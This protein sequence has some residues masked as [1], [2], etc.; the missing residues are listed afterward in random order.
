MK[1]LVLVIAATAFAYGATGADYDFFDGA[2]YPGAAGRKP[3]V[4]LYRVEQEG[5][6]HDEGHRRRVVHWWPRKGVDIIEIKKGM[7]LR[8]WTFR[9]RQFD[10]KS[11]TVHPI[12]GVDE[13][14]RRLPVTQPRKIK[15]HLVGFRGIGNRAAAWSF[16]TNYCPAVV[17]RLESGIKRCFIRRTFIEED[18]A[19]ILDTYE[20][21]MDRVRAGLL[22]VKYSIG[23]RTKKEW[24]ADT[25]PGAPGRLRVE[26]EHFVWLAGSQHAP[27]ESF[28]PWINRDDP[29]KARLWREGSVSYAEDW[30]AYQEHAGVLM[31][32]WDRES[33]GKYGIKVCGTYMDGKTWIGGYAG[34]G[35]GGCGIKHAGGGP[36]ALGLSHEWGH[37]LPLQHGLGVGGGE[38]LADTCQVIADPA[39]VDKVVNQMLRPW[40][41]CF[42]AAYG[43]GLFYALVGDDPNWGYCFGIAMPIGKEEPTALH[44]M[45]RVGEQRG[46]F[47]NGIRGLGDT[48]GEY[49][50]RMAELDCEMQD[51]LRRMYISVK[52][53]WLEPVDR[54]AGLYRIPR[55]EAPEPFGAN[56]IRL[57]PA[58][59]AEKITVDFRGIV[60]PGT[61]ADWR[62]CIVAVGKDG[63]CR[64][65]P[66]WS[67]GKMS[68][69]LR[70]GDRRHW[71]TVAATPWALPTLGHRW[72]TQLFWSRHAFRYPYEVTL[73]GCRPGTPHNL[74]ADTDDYG[75]AYIDGFRRVH[76]GLC[77]IPDPGD[78]P[79]APRIRE[80]ITALRA[81]LKT[82]REETNRLA[83][84]EKISTWHWWYKRR[85]TPQ[86]EFL[87]DCSA[88]MLDGTEG[89][90][91]PNGG[92]WV[93][94]SA[95]V[96]PTAYVG[97]DCM[98][99]QGA[100]VLDHASLED[101][102][103]VRGPRAVVSGH[104]RLHGQAYV[105]GH[106]HVGGYTR[107]RQ[108]VH[109]N[110]EEPF[111]PHEV[112]VRERHTPGED[113]PIWANYEFNREEKVLLEDWYRY[114]S[115]GHPRRFYHVIHNGRLH[116]GPAFVADGERRGFRFDG[117]TQYAE[118]SPTLADLGAVT[119]HFALKWE[120]GTNQAVFDFGTSADHCMVFAPQGASGKAELLITREGKT[121]RV[122]ADAALPKGKWAECRLEIDG[123]TIVLWLDGRKAAEKASSFRAADVYPAGAV[124]RNFLAAK[125]DG[126]AKFKGVLDYLRVWHAVFDD[127]AKAPTAR[128]HAPRRITKEFI[129]WHAKEFG[130]A[131]EKED[132][133]E[134]QAGVRLL[135]AD[136]QAAGP[137][138]R[139]GPEKPR[140]QGG[141][142]ARERL[143]GDVRVARLQPPLQLPV[144]ALPPGQD[145]QGHRR[146]GEPRERRAGHGPRAADERQVAHALRLGMAHE[147]G[148]G[149]LRRETAAPAE[150]DPE[151]TGAGDGGEAGGEGEVKSNVQHRTSNIE[152]RRK[153]RRLPTS[154][155]D[156]QCSMFDVR[157]FR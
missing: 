13:L 66:L 140:R 46:L 67:K 94:A 64:Y 105:S 101:Y 58:K 14:I 59:G 43:T 117:K 82:F 103:V 118:A 112:A 86:L 79:H 55:D 76:S 134:V 21:A 1:K 34:G 65:S 42:H 119:V 111:V 33:Q 78:T 11:A 15:A 10:P 81:K 131:A 6:P 95:K 19:Y 135:P 25:K 63:L 92:G 17:L 98:V 145:R 156:V 85:F 139:R 62:A 44:V 120:G 73:T 39:T 70:P 72:V 35:Y 31:P 3:G 24:P 90:R 108:P 122:I 16:P 45:A 115:P 12:K 49:A 37:G 153:R 28:S 60:D 109:A 114:K 52:R 50:A 155:F 152:R 29:Q 132:P 149:R 68:L 141:A 77:L 125:R 87:D 144:P 154:M 89:A 138:T 74:L 142:Q 51:I 4:D 106:V 123:K 99:L 150:V 133:G 56:I 48:M 54:K 47:A 129:A 124:K 113:G 121:E 84:A 69:A 71:L 32:F 23:E 26:S 5:G 36:W 102:A 75:L 126:S 57:I 38:T 147:T 61:H 30:W 97:P 93:A 107:V 143:A 137:G 27:Q 7:P 20:K 130:G 148:D 88:W 110:K 91:H 104:A 146:Q 83:A 18:E 96:A 40:R 9:D 41:N 53:N 151:S 136:P 2:R 8:T 128:R 22:K 116:G 127:F 80:G 157:S 100:K